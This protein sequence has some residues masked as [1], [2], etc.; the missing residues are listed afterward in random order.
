MEVIKI[1]SYYEFIEH[2]GGYPRSSFC[3]Y[4]Y[5][6]INAEY[7][8][9]PSICYDNMVRRIKSFQDYE[10]CLM[11]GFAKELANNYNTA[12]YK[13]NDRE[14]WFIARHFRLKSRMMD[15]TKDDRIA[16]QFAMDN[17]P[18]GLARIYCLDYSGI[19]FIQQ[20]DLIEKQIDP[21]NYDMLCLIHL[22]TTYKENV[23]KKLGISRILI[24]MGDFLYQPLSTIRK[25]I[26]SQI[27][28][29]F[30]KIFEIHY[31]HFDKIKKEI[32]MK[33]N[34]LM[35]RDLLKEA[36]LLDDHCKHLNLNLCCK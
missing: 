11:R 20:E 18:N 33:D 2:F 32:E 26:N 31:H 36:S 22:G 24:Q 29:H 28:D 34:I 35:N 6:G 25:P 23:I 21:F 16:I 10:E 9:I 30:W 19:K 13:F 7:P 1:S 12:Q 27:P 15:F 17:S 14:T 3:P 4:Y 5:R 8:L